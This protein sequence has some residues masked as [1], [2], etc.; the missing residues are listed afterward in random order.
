MR[1]PSFAVTVGAGLAGAALAAVA[2]GRP[3]A[4]SDADAAGIKVTASV[5]GAQAEPLAVALALVTLAAWGAV[6][7]LRGR[8]RRTVAGAGLLASGG[9]VVAV[10][11]GF[12]SA[13]SDALAAV[14]AKGASGGTFGTSL[15]GWYLAAGIGALVATAAFAVAVVR[16]PGWPEM[17]SRYDAPAAR[18]EAP[19]SDQDM[20]RA[21]DEGR[22][23][24]S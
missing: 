11:L 3:W 9:A 14:M 13:R 15:T 7:V 21:L 20:W 18:A 1:E 5:T 17:G 2:G 24:T 23:P 19:Q 10:L 16:S 4:V 8:S 22:D 12:R 6:L